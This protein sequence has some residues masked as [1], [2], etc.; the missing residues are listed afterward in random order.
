VHSLLSSGVQVHVRRQGDGV[1]FSLLALRRHLSPVLSA[2]H[3]E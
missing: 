3:L 1:L 2:R